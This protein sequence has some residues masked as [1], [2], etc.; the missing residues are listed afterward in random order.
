[1]RWNLCLRWKPGTVCRGAN[2]KDGEEN[3]R[4][5]AGEE[6]GGDWGNAEFTLLPVP[7]PIPSARRP[8]YQH[9]VGDTD[10]RL[11]GGCGCNGDLRAKALASAAAHICVWAARLGGGQRSAPTVAL[12]TR[13]D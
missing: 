8:K 10:G 2:S 3:C 13:D 12:N 4:K 7:V 5:T 9:A 11:Q 6:V 1:M